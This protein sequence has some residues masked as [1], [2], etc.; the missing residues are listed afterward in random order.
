MIPIQR[1][2]T[3][4][5]VL[6]VVGLIAILVTILFINGPTNLSQVRTTETVSFL[7]KLKSAIDQYKLDAGEYPPSSVNGVFTTGSDLL[8]AALQTGI[9]DSGK[10]DLKWHG[11]YLKNL[12]PKY[13]GR[14]QDGV[15]NY[16]PLVYVFA[17]G[18][19][20]SLV[21]RIFVDSFRYPILYVRADDYARIG[22][23]ID[24][25][26]AANAGRNPY[27][28]STSFQLISV[29]PDGMTKAGELGGL[30][31]NDFADNDSDGFTDREDSHRSISNGTLAEDDLAL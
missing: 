19:K 23:K 13:I 28:N 10:G 9:N 17:D 21:D 31:I 4:L 29:G 5:E 2:F 1:G 18:S 22:A 25:L 6:I 20:P 15:P 14:V 27:L 11:P 26:S 12:D 3:L 8:Y 24:N 16:T 30:A 7:E